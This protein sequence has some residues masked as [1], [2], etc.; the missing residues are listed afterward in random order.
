MKDNGNDRNQDLSYLQGY[1]HALAI[2]NS[3]VDRGKTYTVD[4]LSKVNDNVQDSLRN[5]YGVKY[6]GITEKPIGRNWHEPFRVLVQPFFEEIL[7]EAFVLAKPEAIRDGKGRYR[8]D[9]ARNAIQEFV[10]NRNFNTQYLMQ[11]LISRIEGITGPGAQLVHVEVTD[12]VPEVP[13]ESFYEC[14]AQDFVFDLGKEY[15]Y[16]HFGVSD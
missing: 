13:Y 8:T 12:S 11:E 1:L 16:L 6:W 14:Y 4:L 10:A 7:Q 3:F 5:Y 15:L 2:M 9:I